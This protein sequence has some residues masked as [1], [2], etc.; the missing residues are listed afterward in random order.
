MT[1]EIVQ[2]YLE[3]FLRDESSKISENNKIVKEN[4]AETTKLTDEILYL[5][6]TALIFHNTTCSK[7]NLQLD[8]PA[9]H[10]MCK[11]SYHERCAIEG[12]C[13]ICFEKNQKVLTKRD[14]SLLNEKSID[15]F[16][17][18]IKNKDGVENIIEYFGYNLFDNVNY[19]Y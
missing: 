16:Y 2:K 17:K 4:H 9:I 19:F 5:R 8:L 6:T 11:H 13:S 10:F 7:C 3:D 15:D 14:Q 18:S 12:E 1:I